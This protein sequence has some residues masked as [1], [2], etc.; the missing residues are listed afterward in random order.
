MNRAAKV[1]TYGGE[2]RGSYKTVRHWQLH[3][4]GRFIADTSTPQDAEL[5]AR[6]AEAWNKRE[7]N[8]G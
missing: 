4:A 6:I 1:T 8:A 3:V 2:D 5:F 7:D